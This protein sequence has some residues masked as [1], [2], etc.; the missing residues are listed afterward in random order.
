MTNYKFLLLPVGSAGDVHP[1]LGLAIELRRRGH[2]VVLGVC[3]AFEDAAQRTGARYV[4]IGTAEDYDAAVRNPD[5]WKPGMKSL[6]V[7]AQLACEAGQKQ[8]E[9]VRDEFEPGR[10]IVAA[11]ALAFGARIAQEKFDVPT[12][13]IQLAPSVFYS[14][15]SPPRLPLLWMPD[16]MPHLLKRGIWRLASAAGDSAAKRP[17]NELRQQWGLGP[18]RDIFGS[19][20]HSPQRVIGMFP[21]WFAPPPGDWP[22][23]L[24]LTDFPLFD[25]GSDTSLP[26]T[27][28]AFL[29]AGD[30]PIVFAPG[31]ANAQA[32]SFFSAAVKACNTLERR[33]VLLTKYV[34]QAPSNL[35]A[36]VLHV[37]YAPLTT[38]LP[39]AAALVHTGGIGTLSQ[40]LAAGVPQV[41]R[42]MVHDQYDNASR[43]VALGVAEEIDRRRFNGAAL[44]GA[45]DR[46]LTDPAVAASA[47]QCAARLVD[48]R[49][50]PDTCD[51]L[52]QLAP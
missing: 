39:R 42:P 23:Q 35:P 21:D 43:A 2:E 44:A 29:D 36:N 11:G 50:I 16:W 10:T 4:E 27:L 9:V 45:L 33:G 37:D 6:R 26:E 52:E 48:R 17:I 31:S 3:G 8:V 41:I 30:P 40:G 34:D 25:D 49:G 14:C 15:E 38:L 46:L 51:L 12:A 13:S 24:R 32:R 5:L 7:V 18:V 20:W 19:W 28:E 22:E 1:F 47:T